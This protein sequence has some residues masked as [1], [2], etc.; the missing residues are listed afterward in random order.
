MLPQNVNNKQT[1]P[2]P[3][4]RVCHS[5]IPPSL[6]NSAATKTKGTLFSAKS[7]TQKYVYFDRNQKEMISLSR[8]DRE[9]DALPDDCFC[10]SDV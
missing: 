10:G 6:N 7:S 4:G 3:G 9:G 5:I 8:Q 1:R 2:D